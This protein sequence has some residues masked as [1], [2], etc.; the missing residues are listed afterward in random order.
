MRTYVGICLCILV[1]GVL[2][3]RLLWP[4]L[5][6]LS[7]TPFVVVEV[8]SLMLAVTLHMSGWRCWSYLCHA[9]KRLK[10]ANMIA[11]PSVPYG[12]MSGVILATWAVLYI[13]VSVRLSECDSHWWPGVGMLM[14]VMVYTVVKLSRSASRSSS[15]DSEF[16]MENASGP[17]SFSDVSSCADNMGDVSSSDNVKEISSS[18]DS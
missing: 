10:S 4:C 1:S 7:W 9:R 15:S 13:V 14:L 6:E 11:R 12:P 16:S 17:G 8:L 18:E 3:A 2:L 5:H